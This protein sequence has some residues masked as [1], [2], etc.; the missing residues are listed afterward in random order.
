MEQVKNIPVGM[1]PILIDNVLD[2]GK[3]A[4]NA[5]KALNMDTTK[6]AVLGDTIK[7][8]HNSYTPYWRFHFKNGEV[9]MLLRDAYLK[10]GDRF[11]IED[12]RYTVLNVYPP[13]TAKEGDTI[14]GKRLGITVFQ[15]RLKVCTFARTNYYEYG[16]QR[17]VQESP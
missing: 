10:P 12:N 16:K 14:V 6:M 9:S 3:T 17:Q 8:T 11:K 13:R 4:S 1:F 5:Y 15:P 2:T 7:F